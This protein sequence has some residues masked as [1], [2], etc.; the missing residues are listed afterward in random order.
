M[1]KPLIGQRVKYTAEFIA[2]MGHNKDFAEMTGEIVSIKKLSA[3]ATYCRIKWDGEE[4]E[5]GCLAQY[6]APVGSLE[7]VDCDI[8]KAVNS[9]KNQLT[10]GMN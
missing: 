4:E 7:L 10:G 9:P 8:A 2:K 3:T 5:K 6:I 1:R